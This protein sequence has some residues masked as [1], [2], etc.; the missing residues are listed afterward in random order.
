MTNV[1]RTLQAIVALSIPLFVQPIHASDLILSAN[2]GKFQR[3]EGNATYPSPAPS[4]SLVVI[5]A[6]HFPPVVKATLEGIDHTIQGPPQAVAI[7]PNGKLAVV[8]AP[9]R[10]D[11]A[12][13]KETL[14][15]FLQVVDIESSPPKL[16][17]KVELGVH[18]NGLSINPDGTLLLAAAL[19]GTLKV[20]AIKDNGLTL[21]DSIKLGEKRLSGVTFTHDGKA[22]IVALRDEQGAAI[23][24]VDATGVKDTGERLS[25]GVSPYSV[26]VDSNGHWAVISNVGLAGKPGN[27]GKIFGDADS[28]TLVDV[29]KRPFRS[30]QHLTVPAIPEG[31][32]ISPDGKWI[33][34]QAMDGSQLTTDN[35]G[36]HPRGKVVLFALDKN[37]AHK[38]NEVPGGEAAQ[39]IVFA[40]DSRT[41]IVQFDVEKELAIYRVVGGKLVDTT[42]RIKLAAGPVSIRSMPR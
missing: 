5:D 8:A 40:K 41:V 11:Y 18:I 35:P 13:K 39:G 22:A 12:A 36:R 25:T 4:D 27:F 10:Y 37:G 20:L 29:T 42:K 7:T 38:V 19:D 15:T 28:V 2:D 3:V 31:V 26:D 32:S 23:L 9:S 14:E 1:R 34:V 24:S 6:S 30:V 16:V 21:L 33:V 17:D